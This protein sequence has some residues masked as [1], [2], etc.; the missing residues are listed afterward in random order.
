M[1]RLFKPM[2]CVAAAAVLSLSMIQTAFAASFNYYS[3]FPSR[4]GTTSKNTTTKPTTTQSTTKSTTNNTSASTASGNTSAESQ[5]LSMINEDRADAGLKPLKADSS[6][7]SG[8][9]K[10][11]QDMAKN[12]FFSHTSPTNGTFS[13][14]AS[15]AG[16]SAENIAMYGSVAKAHAGLM[17][18]EGHRKNLMN[19]NYTRIGIGIVYNSSKGAYYI[20]QWF[21]R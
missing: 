6:L 11:S 17:G 15:G 9:L 20:T 1:K 7:R 2:L 3:Y 5:M 16:A 12:N 10:H 13:Q 19:A 8:A 14:R 21:G 18:S 4:Y